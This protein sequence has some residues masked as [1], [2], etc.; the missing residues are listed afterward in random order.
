M[1]PGR[2]FA[3]QQ[4]STSVATMVTRFDFEVAGFVEHNGKPSARG[5]ETD[6][7]NNGLGTIIPDRDCLV[8][9]RIRS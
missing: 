2:L 5:P 3:K 4:V 7:R 8:T 9:I 1:C 6:P